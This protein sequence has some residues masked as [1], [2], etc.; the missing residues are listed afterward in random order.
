MT[1]QHIG[2]DFTTQVKLNL[3]P[4]IK[5][6]RGVYQLQ[7]QYMTDVGSVTTM[8]H[9]SHN[10]LMGKPTEFDMIVGRDVRYLDVMI[11]CHNSFPTNPLVN[12]RYS[13]RVDQLLLL[14]MAVKLLKL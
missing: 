3:L 9:I 4:G 1:T 2:Q 13:M 11:C 5:L 12:Y 14:N 8:H 7:I 10:M 6:K